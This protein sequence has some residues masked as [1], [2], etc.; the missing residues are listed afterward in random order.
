[1][2]RS[3]PQRLKY[4]QGES[5]ESFWGVVLT[6]YFTSRADPLRPDRDPGEVSDYDY[7]SLWYNSIKGVGLQAVVFHDSLPQSFLEKYSTR[8]IQYVRVNLAANSSLSQNDERF[9]IYLDFLEAHPR[10]KYVLHTDL[11]DVIINKDPF[12]LMEQLKQQYD[13]FVNVERENWIKVPYRRAYG[14]EYPKQPVMFNAGVFGGKRQAVIDLLRL[15]EGEFS[16]L[17]ALK[18]KRRNYNM[19]VLNRMLFYN[20]RFC[21]RIFT[22]P[23]F[24]AGMVQCDLHF[25]CNYY[26][27]HKYLQ[28]GELPPCDPMP[29]FD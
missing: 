16:R 17:Y 12:H 3:L 14:G 28:V 20:S 8:D 11:R 29:F 25:K 4:I 10:I 23:P 22:G 15:M 6:T 7:M 19:A 21:S 2:C 13:L 27:Y 18:Q 26:V 5:Q 9:L 24:C 1:M